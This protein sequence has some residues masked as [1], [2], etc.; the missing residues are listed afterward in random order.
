VNKLILGIFILGVAVSLL[1]LLPK[2]QKKFVQVGK[3]LMPGVRVNAK[4]GEQET[5]WKEVPSYTIK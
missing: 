2:R 3:V 5:T 4:T 1:G